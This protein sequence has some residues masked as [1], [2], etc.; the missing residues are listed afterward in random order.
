[1][2]IHRNK[3]EHLNKAHKIK[4]SPCNKSQIDMEYFENLN[5]KEY[6]CFNHLKFN[7]YGYHTDNEFQLIKYEI[8][9]CNHNTE[10]SY[11]ITCATDEE[12]K[13]Y[14]KSKIFI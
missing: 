10:E 4:A 8:K 11:N 9:K 12:F 14:S 6:Q 3:K 5:L 7:L 13:N 2:L 1:M